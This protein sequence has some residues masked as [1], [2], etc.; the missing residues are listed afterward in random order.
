MTRAL[1]APVC[2]VSSKDMPVPFSRPLERDTVPTS[3]LVKERILAM[4]G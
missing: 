2:I 3:A 4:L 1:K